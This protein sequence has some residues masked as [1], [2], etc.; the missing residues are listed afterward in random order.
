MRLP[1]GVLVDVLDCTMWVIIRSL[2]GAPPRRPWETWHP[3]NGTLPRPRR[4]TSR[5]QSRLCTIS[6]VL[7]LSPRGPTMPVVRCSRHR[8]TV[9]QACSFPL[10]SIPFPL[11]ILSITSFFATGIGQFQV[12][13]SHDSGAKKV[14]SGLARFP[15]HTTP[16]TGSV[17]SS[18]NVLPPALRGGPHVRSPI[19]RFVWQ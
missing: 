5:I 18:V 19:V 8:D 14:C 16:R 6:V 10:C 15:F 11:L 17:W 4:H 7:F 9:S 13:V 2:K 1:G 12:R 3:P